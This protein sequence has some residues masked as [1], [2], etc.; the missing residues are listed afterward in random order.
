MASAYFQTYMFLVIVQL[1]LWCINLPFK[2]VITHHNL[3]L[4]GDNVRLRSG[5]A[6]LRI[7]PV[8][9]GTSVQLHAN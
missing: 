9:N 1:T 7:H 4:P 5:I 6:S 3:V 8:R 2:M